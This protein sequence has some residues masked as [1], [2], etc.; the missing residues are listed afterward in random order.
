MWKTSN[1]PASPEALIPVL[2]M[3]DD[4]LAEK[5][6]RCMEVNEGAQII[7]DHGFV[8]LIETWGS[9]EDIIESA[10]MST[11]KGFQGWG[12]YCPHCGSPPEDLQ[13]TKCSRGGGHE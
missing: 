11:S 2:L 7:L 13:V 12:P 1:L 6:G 5:V 4:V 3:L 10:R 9:D 8:S